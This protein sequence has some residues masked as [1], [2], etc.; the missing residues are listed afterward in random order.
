MSRPPELKTL[1]SKHRVLTWRNGAGRTRGLY[2]QRRGQFVQASITGFGYRPRNLI[3]PSWEVLAWSAAKIS[4]AWGRGWT[5]TGLK[6][7]TLIEKAA[8]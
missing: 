8:P 7:R 5:P 1:S 3:L 6:A 2:A 4:A